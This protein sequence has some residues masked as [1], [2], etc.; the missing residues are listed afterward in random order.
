[1]D[2]PPGFEIGPMTEP[3]ID[4]LGYWAEAEGWNPGHGD[5]RVVRAVDPD[6]FVALRREGEMVGGGSIF[7]HA[8]TLGFMGLFI[9]RPDVRGRGLGAR[10]WT[11]RRDALLRRLGP[12]AS[13]GMDGVFAM[14]PF[15]Q[16]GGFRPAWR[17]LRFEGIASGGGVGRSTPLA[18]ADMPE[19][20]AF[21]QR[22]FG[23]VRPDF[24]ARW[25][26]RPGV[27][28]RVLRR[29]GRLAAFGVCRPCVTSVRVGPLFAEDA[30][31]ARALLADLLAPHAGAQVQ[32]DVPEPNAA[33]LALAADL[34]LAEVF[35]CVRLYLGPV[36]DLPTDR[37]FGVTSLEFG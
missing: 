27:S 5:L 19:V 2:L 20:L 16:R 23:A 4:V 11:W 7:R 24:L 12:G 30:G 28:A 34:G 22:C 18:P 17:D 15:Y 9:L 3:E 13:I 8:P 1:M 14:V 21:D 26:G 29:A 35:G 10:L 37:I 32:I 33:G 25:I 31:A 36:P 6:A